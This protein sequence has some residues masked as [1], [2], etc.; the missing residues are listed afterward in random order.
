MAGR[1]RRPRAAGRSL[2]PRPEAA[3][4]ADDGPRLL[5]VSDRSP[6][7]WFVLL[8]SIAPVPLIAWLVLLPAEADL[9]AEFGSP[10]AVRAWQAGM[11]LVSTVLVWPM[12]WLCGRYV[13]RVERLPDRQ[14]RIEVWTWFGRRRRIWPARFG[15]GEDHAGQSALPGAPL[16]NAPWTGYRTPAGKRLVVDWQGDFPHGS[17]VLEEALCATTE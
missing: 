11:L 15:A 12:V 2:A 9:L 6:T 7:L 13:T 17:E 14:V 5:Y 1:R 8:V 10:T 16:V 3:Q 4:P